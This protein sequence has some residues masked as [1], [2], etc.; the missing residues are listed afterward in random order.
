MI[1]YLTTLLLLS[2][3]VASV[4]DGF[5]F[6]ITYKQQM[7]KEDGN[8]RLITFLIIKSFLK[9]VMIASTKQ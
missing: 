1:F 4:L 8:N 6:R 7:S 3:V 9:L 2:I 5:I